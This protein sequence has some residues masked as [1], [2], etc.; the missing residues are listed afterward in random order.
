MSEPKLTIREYFN[1][2]GA[3]PELLAACRAAVK[4][5]GRRYGHPD[6]L[7]THWEPIDQQLRDAIAKATGEDHR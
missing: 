3:A 7:P 2:I 6:D 1:L 5:L 4:E